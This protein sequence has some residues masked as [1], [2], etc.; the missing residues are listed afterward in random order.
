MNRLI[1]AAAAAISTASFATVASAQISYENVCASKGANGYVISGLP[2]TLTDYA[3][4]EII[5]AALGDGN[6]ATWTVD[7]TANIRAGGI[8]HMNGSA[9]VDQ[10]PYTET[11][12]LSAGRITAPWQGFAP[13]R[14][15]GLP[16][17]KG[18]RGDKWKLMS[19]DGSNHTY[20]LV[21]RGN[22]PWPKGSTYV[23]TDQDI[24][25]RDYLGGT[26]TKPNDAAWND[27]LR[28]AAERD[29]VD[30]KQTTVKYA[31]VTKYVE[32]C[33]TAWDYTFSDQNGNVVA[34]LN[35]EVKPCTMKRV[36][37]KSEV[38]GSGTVTLGSL[39]GQKRVASN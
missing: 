37:T 17:S 7:A 20:K 6:C 1:I 22:H 9:H 15:K 26:S 36:T 28:Y 4:K 5:G 29:R 19:S 25:D 24:I 8:S 35:G 34:V 10:T 16:I 27:K 23:F 39:F 3:T 33:P 18:G 21:K 13:E 32:V 14:L 30:T 11:T 2:S 31:T 38:S 12:V